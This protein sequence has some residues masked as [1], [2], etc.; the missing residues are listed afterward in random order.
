ML[1]VGVL[2]CGWIHMCLPQT[3]PSEGGT[4]PA[5]VLSVVLGVD[6]KVKR[7]FGS[8][9]LMQ[10]VVVVVFVFCHSKKHKWEPAQPK[11]SRVSEMVSAH[12]NQS[13]QLKATVQRFDIGNFLL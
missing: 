5:C 10:F 7:H 3:C 6:V 13:D 8:S 4:F 12:L 9:P 11:Q 1:G 2:D